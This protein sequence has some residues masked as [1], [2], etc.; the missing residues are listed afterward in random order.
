MRR[1]PVS[2]ALLCLG[3][4]ACGGGGHPSAHRPRHPDI[5]R[6]P[7]I[8]SVDV[9]SSLP[10]EGPHR[11]ATKAIENG[12]NLALDEAHGQE[13][14]V[15]KINYRPLDDATKRSHG[16][17]ARR[18]L[19]NALRAARDPKA[20]YYIGEFDSGA[21]EFSIPILNQAGI[22]Q[23]SPASGYV[24]LT[25]QVPAAPAATLRKPS[26][27]PPEPNRYYP[28]GTNSRNF[29]RLI[30][31]DDVQAAAAVQ[32]LHETLGCT[33]AGLASDETQRGISLAALIRAS[34]PMFG[35]TVDA[36]QQIDP[37]AKQAELRGY[38]EHLA[39][40]GV[41]CL[42]FAGSMSPAAVDLVKE[43]RL[44]LP[45]LPI[46]GTDSV[47]AR[48]WMRYA[49]MYCMRPTLNFKDY[50]GGP[51]ILRL[52]RHLYGQHTHPSAWALYGYEAMELGIDTISR[53]GRGGAGREA[54]RR[55]LFATVERQSALGTYTIT[56][57]GNTTLTTFGLYRS[58]AHGGPRL[59]KKV[60]PAPRILPGS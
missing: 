31:S 21:S 26:N 32:A 17:S 45:S 57:Q 4:S 34:A 44:L 40:E 51:E 60:N 24:G 9:Y 12:I 19:A 56:S 33:H 22:A 35:V 10:Q 23:V 3:L 5:H 41:G 15:L 46:L 30:P 2:L 25:E 42:V 49:Y 1:A 50:P 54:V 13:A 27:Q 8:T 36:A 58:S 37:Q 20:V 11:A 39:H 43:V 38:A 59:L 29:V 6:P 52:Y 14:G 53:L 16:W 47:C 28:A 55:A 18:T 48:A 7:P